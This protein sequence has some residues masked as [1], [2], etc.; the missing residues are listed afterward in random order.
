MDGQFRVLPG[1]TPAGLLSDS[2]H[3]GGSLPAEYQARRR[4]E[5]D[6]ADG[7]PFHLDIVEATIGLCTSAARELA[8]LLQVV[9]APLDCFSFVV[10][11]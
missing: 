3:A 5:V 1:S 7:N 4:L 10:H 2:L 6:V 9:S 8:V 11:V